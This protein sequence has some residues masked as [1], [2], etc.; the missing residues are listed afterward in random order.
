MY[1]KVTPDVRPT[2][3]TEHVLPSGIAG[4]ASTLAIVEDEDDTGGF[5]LFGLDAEGSVET[6]RW[7]E[8]VEAALDQAVWE[9]IGLAW[10]DVSP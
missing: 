3:A 5:F 9:Y 6:D 4:P 7:H 10:A 2:G 8:P 1:A